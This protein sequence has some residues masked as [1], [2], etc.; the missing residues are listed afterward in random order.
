MPFQLCGFLENTERDQYCI[1]SCGISCV[2]F[3]FTCQFSILLQS[4]NKA[5]GAGATVRTDC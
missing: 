1:P 4:H 5:A 2:L 3:G